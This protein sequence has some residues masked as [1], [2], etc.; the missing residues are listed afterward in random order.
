MIA[1]PIVRFKVWL[2]IALSIAGVALHSSAFGADVPTSTT[3]TRGPLWL[4]VRDY[5]ALPGTT[6]CAANRAAIQAAIDAP[7]PTGITRKTVYI[8]SD[9]AGWWLDGPLWLDKPGI[10]IQG[11]GLGQT[12]LNSFVYSFPPI[13][14]GV[15]RNP[16]S[17]AGEKTQPSA[18]NWVDL[19]GK[20][21]SSVA[22]APGQNRWGYRT[23]GDTLLVFPSGGLTLGPRPSGWQ[24]VKTL[25]L[26]FAV[27]MSTTNLPSSGI[28]CGLWSAD[29]ASPWGVYYN[30]GYV[31]LSLQTADGVKRSFLM[32]APTLNGVTRI[33]FQVDL[34]TG[35]VLG[36]LNKTQVA[37]IMNQAGAGWSNGNQQ[38]ADR[39]VSH[40]GI[41]FESRSLGPSDYWGGASVVPPGASHALG[42]SDITMLGLKVSDGAKYANLGAGQPQTRVD[43]GPVNDAILFTDDAGTIDYIIN[44]IGPTTMSNPRMIRSA[45][46]YGLMLA[47]GNAYDGVMV[48]DCSI[49]DLTISTI[50]NYGHALAMGIVNHFEVD[51]F[52]TKS[53]AYGIGAI[54][55]AAN[56]KNRFTNCRL[57]GTE[58]NL[59]TYFAMSEVTGLR[60]AA[61]GRRGIF[62]AGSS[63]KLD[64]GFI[65]NG[66]ATEDVYRAVARDGGGVHEINGLDTDF[67]GVDIP[68]HSLYSFEADRYAPNVVMIRGGTHG[69]IGSKAVVL[70]LR[71]NQAPNDPAVPF[72]YASIEG[73]RTFLGQVPGG[74]LRTDGKWKGDIRVDGDRVSQPI[75]GGLVR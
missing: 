19:G 55:I 63:L 8:P 21:D 41:G 45:R 17:F 52:E 34:A 49:R 68:S 70:D 3:N 13:L 12:N 25:L 14:A 27:D 2:A 31:I 26:E 22:T 16:I 1:S 71:S 62:T 30:S 42:Y 61:A 40:F 43:G 65:G 29:K 72:G 67:E 28:F 74:Y 9:P 5:G 38:L 10:T 66:V 24:S 32:P 58:A 37:V 33:A 64:G 73:V 60:V 75:L 7:L 39:G 51:D 54:N 44:L 59:Y 18:A 47:P 69:T 48:R 15:T 50:G 23:W 46:A 53:G 4:D 35:T 11:D 6:N 20:L 57:S 36:W 56:Y